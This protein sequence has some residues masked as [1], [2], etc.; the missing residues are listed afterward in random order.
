MKSL[1]AIAIITTGFAVLSGCGESSDLSKSD[2][3][4][5]RKNLSRPLNSE[6]LSH[7]GQAAKEAPRAN[8]SGPSKF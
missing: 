6:E 4:A 2:D 8:N 5:L 7:M 3:E 1:I